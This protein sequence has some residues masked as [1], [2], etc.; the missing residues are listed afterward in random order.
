MDYRVGAA[1]SLPLD[2]QSATVL[3][4]IASV[5]HWPALDEGLREVHRVLQPGGR[6]VAVERQ[7]QPG[8]TGHASHGWTTEQANAFA[9]RCRG[10]GFADVRVEHHRV[11]Q[12]KLITVIASRP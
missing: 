10:A 11:G 8:A 9:E 4:S 6:F 5:H 3:W 12:R 2:D 7:T 1:E